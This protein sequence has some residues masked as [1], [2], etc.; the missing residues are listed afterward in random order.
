MSTQLGG[1]VD[2]IVPTRSSPLPD[3]S[4]E[5]AAALASSKSEKLTSNIFPDIE[6]HVTRLIL[7]PL[8][9]NKIESEELVVDDVEKSFDNNEV[10]YENLG[11]TIA[12]TNLG[13]LFNKVYVFSLNKLPKKIVF[14]TLLTCTMYIV[15]GQRGLKLLTRHWLL[16]NFFSDIGDFSC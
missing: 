1:G 11:E 9:L 3:T 12:V 10:S 4:P 5:P 8:S 16:Q 7:I 13:E 15:H 6:L 14:S 2:I